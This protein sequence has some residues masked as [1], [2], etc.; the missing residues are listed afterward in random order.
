MSGRRVRVLNV[1]S[2]LEQSK[3]FELI[4]RHVDLRRLDFRVLFLN[5]PHPTPVPLAASF[6][7]AGIPVESWSFRG[8]RDYP[9]T[10][11]RLTAYLR[12]ERIDAVH[13]HLAWASYVAMPA[14]FAA[15]V[16]VRMLT[17]HHGDEHHRA[18]PGWVKCDRLASW[19]ATRVITPGVV[20]H[21]IVT[22]WERVPPRK[23]RLL[24][25][26][27]D[28]ARFRS[29]SPAAVEAVRR[30]YNPDGR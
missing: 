15:A 6:E 11:A 7:A 26:P 9:R 2:H 29:P 12:R 23:V 28:A 8:Y 24:P 20:T 13:A 10:L 5:P 21:R 18:H 25:L 27:V 4:A 16:P 3:M 17:R 14:A 1:L 22:E 19:F 30:E